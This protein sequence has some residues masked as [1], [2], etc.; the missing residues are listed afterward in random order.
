MQV[1]VEDVN[2]VKKILHIV[3]PEEKVADEINDTYNTLG[4][5][6]K[7]KGFR[8]GK[9][10]RSVLKRLY[11]K[12]VNA[13]V[14]SKLIQESFADAIKETDLKIVGQ[15][16][17]DPPE[18][19]GQGEYKF[20]A[21]VEINPELGDI[22]YKELALEKTKYKV[23]EEEIETQL[24][25]VQKNLARLEPIKEDRPVADGDIILMDYEGFKDGEPYSETEKTENYTM[26][27][28][29]GQISADLDEQLKGMNASEEKEISV[30]FPDDH[31]NEKLAGMEIAF[32]VKLKEI[33]EEILPD[34]DDEF[35]KKTGQYQTLD[36][37]K[38]SILD[39]L[40]KGYEKR[41]EQELQEQIF[42]FIL[43]KQDFE[44]PDFMVNMELE[45]IITEA[46]R[47][48]S[49]HNTSMEQLGITRD[50]LSEK[51]RG[52]ALKQVKRHL[53]L[54]KLVEQE[55]MTIS[56]D[57]LEN[58]IKQMAETVQQP[59]SELN[60]FYTEN[61]E[62][63]EYLKHTLLEK[64]ALNLIIESSHIKNIEPR[65]SEPETDE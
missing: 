47:S 56:G 7:I 27:I 16:E 40:E 58:E 37:L 64:R 53:I 61:K 55:Q 57:E 38:K 29:K 14:S 52:I 32:S 39:N 20:D 33:R 35:A 31:D 10:P 19:K 28:G 24:K 13:D 6:A 18:F 25:M 30:R 21:T 50:S 11:G 60:S 17:I 41:S 2:A 23:S 62:Q 26:K 22:D 12:N 59:F 34:I 48:F 49:Y 63:L 3:I 15:P 54:K 51:Y 43:E 44:V 65:T 42:K 9:A 36:E 45:G 4:K 5:T 8:P 1:N 46:E